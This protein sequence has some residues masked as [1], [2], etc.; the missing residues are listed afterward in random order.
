MNTTS[1]AIEALMNSSDT[2]TVAI[3]TA[4][5]RSRNSST[6]PS[7]ARSPVRLRMRLP[8]RPQQARGQRDEREG[9]RVD[10]HRRLGAAGSGERAAEHGSRRHAGVAGRLDGPVELPLPM[11]GTSANSAGWATAK[12]APSSA[13]RASVAAVESSVSASAAATTACAT[14]R[15]QQQP[16]R[17]DAVGQQPGGRRE[18]DDRAPQADHQ[19]GDRRPGARLLVHV[20]RERDPEQEVA[21]RRDPDRSDDEPAV[22]GHAARVSAVGGGTLPLARNRLSGSHTALIQARRS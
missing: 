15:P 6:M 9:R 11:T 5:V 19:R 21:E 14:R 20:Q 1:A 7:R 4:S 12:P 10:E 13:A 18:Q 8:A 16:A 3:T 22:A 17:L 2:S